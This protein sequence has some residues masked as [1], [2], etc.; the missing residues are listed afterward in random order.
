METVL[1]VLRHAFCITLGLA[2]LVLGIYL[3]REFVEDCAYLSY[4]L[5]GAVLNLLFGVCFV[6]CGLTL[7]V[8]PFVIKP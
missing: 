3:L 1:I 5:L 4:R 8:V 7:M 6:L 2:F